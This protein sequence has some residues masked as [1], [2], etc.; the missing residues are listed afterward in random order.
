MLKIIL[1]L[2]VVQPPTPRVLKSVTVA[3]LAKKTEVKVTLKVGEKVEEKVV[4]KV[5]KVIAN[6][7]LRKKGNREVQ[8]VKIY[9]DLNFLLGSD[10]Q[11]NF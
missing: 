3:M 5:K 9:K 7:E 10:P 4:I 2:L 11:P 6:Q 1:L 8:V